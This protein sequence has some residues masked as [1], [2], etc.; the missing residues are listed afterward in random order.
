M[1]PPDPDCIRTIEE[2]KGWTR[3]HLHP[4][5]PHESAIFGLGYFHAGGVGVDYLLTVDYP[6]AHIESVRNRAGAIDTPIVRRWL[7]TLKPQIFEADHPWPETP[8]PWLE[9]FRRHGLRNALAHVWVDPARCV[10]TYYS[11][12]QLPAS[13]GAREIEILERLI[14]PLH[15][16]L[17][18]LLGHDPKTRAAQAFR[19]LSERQREL[20][21]WVRL[22]KTNAEI[23][24]VTGVS[25]NTIK[26]GLSDLYDRLQVSNRAGL[27]GLLIEHETRQAPTSRTRIF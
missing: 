6:L 18:R 22:G 10:G 19:P 25:E 3:A 1:L 23:A 7:A 20:I 8:A 4:I 5:L 26:H 11:F 21:D 14:P 17:V 16:A 12:Y 24:L 13:P 2:F 15:E 27:L 9:S